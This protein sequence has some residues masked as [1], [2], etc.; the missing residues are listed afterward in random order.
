MKKILRLGTRG[1]PLAIIQA[2]DVRKKIFSAHPQLQTE[3]EIELVPIRT[4]G[5]WKAG[6]K[7]ISFAE[8]GTQGKDLF[9]KEIEDAL[10]ANFIDM[11]VHSM[12]DVATLLPQDT[13]IAA[14]LE[15]ADPRDAFIG[16]S[17]RT[18]DALSKGAVVGTASI[19]RQAQILARRP[20]LKI[21]PLRGNVNTRL[22]KL[23]NGDVD[24]TILAVAGL[25]RLGV[26][27]RISSILDTDVMLPSAAQGTIA[28]QIRRSDAEARRLL[29]PLHTLPTALCVTAERTFLQVLE[30]SCHTPIAALAQIQKDGT[31]RLEGLVAKPDGSAIFRDH[32]SGSAEKAVELGKELGENIKGRLPSGFFAAA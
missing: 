25:T 17:V 12:K 7:E 19:R 14:L 22:Q 1:S 2:E 32:T 29:T 28:V 23:A 4:S 20:D 27:N 18:L 15:R 9:T 16:R 21:V 13:E 5:D 30:G 6:Q 24:A 10:L 3:A 8:A 11:A 31:L 26:A